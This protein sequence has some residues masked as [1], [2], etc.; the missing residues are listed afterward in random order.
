M[1]GTH[2]KT[3][4][5][6]VKSLGRE[7]ICRVDDGEKGLF[8]A[9]IDNSPEAL[10]RQA[11]IRKKDRQDK[12]DEERANQLIAEQIERARAATEEKAK[13]AGGHVSAESAS[14]KPDQKIQ[15]NFGLKKTSDG[16]PNQSE[17]AHSPS[18]ST[19]TAAGTSTSEETTRQNLESSTSSIAAPITGMQFSM[20]TKPKRAN[21]FANL[22]TSTPLQTSHSSSLHQKGLSNAQQMIIE[23]D[24]RQKRQRTRT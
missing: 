20:M 3:L 21:V 16:A 2:W 18:K 23:Q 22:K 8:I 6:F 7:G 5:E 9:W 4:S 14:R 13:V 1:N 19:S 24:E 12:G 10:N 15:I 17:T 11:A